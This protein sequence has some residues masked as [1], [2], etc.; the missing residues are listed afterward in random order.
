MFKLQRKRL[1]V[2]LVIAFIRSSLHE[3]F[4]K[5]S[6]LKSF[7][8]FRIKHLCQNLF[9]N[10]VAG[11]GIFFWILQNF[12]EHFIYRTLPG[13]CF[14]FALVEAVVISTIWSMILYIDWN[15]FPRN[16]HA[17]VKSDD[18]LSLVKK[19]CTKAPVI[20]TII[21]KREKLWGTISTLYYSK[22][23]RIQQ[24]LEYLQWT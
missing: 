21:Q 5:N 3:V 16:K 2:Y 18:G 23:I 1:G 22:E 12:E 6:L 20:E 19:S 9:L 4:C 15:L 17:S 13:D 24:S 8:K 7:A 11:P 14:C 10:E